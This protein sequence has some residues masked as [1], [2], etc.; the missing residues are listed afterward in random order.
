MQ[1]CSDEELARKAQAGALAAFE[2]LV[3]RYERRVYGFV[4][5]FCRNGTDAAE[6][7]QDTFVRAFQAIAQFDPNHTFA[8]WLFTIARRKCIDHHRAAPPPADEN[9]PDLA[10]TGDPA[11]ALA[12]REERE[13][14]WRLAHQALPEMQFQ[15]LWLRYAEEMN[16]AQ[17]AQVLRKTQTHVKVLLFRARQT[18]A[19]E[20][21]RLPAGAGHP[22]TLSELPASLPTALNKHRGTPATSLAHLK[23]S[24]GLAVA[25]SLSSPGANGASRL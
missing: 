8:A 18:L 16:V 1:F 5:R 2:G 7:T 9:V 19:R 23:P 11:E 22:R 10:A 6:I 15:A 25:S 21:D 13:N 17:V 3:S 24:G 20:L 12:A 14:L 4:V